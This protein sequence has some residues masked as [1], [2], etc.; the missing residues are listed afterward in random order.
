ML[1]AVREK[2][3]K[4]SVR[5][6][7]RLL[8][9]LL[10]TS[11]LLTNVAW[12]AEDRTAQRALYLQALELQALELQSQ[13]QA[14]SPEYQS[15]LE[16]LDGYPLLPYLEYAS[17]SPRIAALAAPGTDHTHVVEF[18]TRN[19]G[20]YLGQRL[21]RE[22]VLALA[23][24]A[25]W[26]DV[27]AHH[28]KANTTTELTCYA[29]RARLET[30][31]TSALQEVAPLWNVSVSQPNVCDPVFE[32]WIAAGYPTPDIA[33]QRFEKTLKAD[34]DSLANYIARQMPAREQ[35]LARLYMRVD[36]EPQALRD[37]PGF[38][39]PADTPETKAI[40][41]HGLRQLAQSDAA[42]ALTLLKR[43]DFDQT[44]SE[45]ERVELER[46]IIMRLL[47][48]G[49]VNEAEVLLQATPALI[50]EALG[51]WILRDALK[52]Q[53]WTRIETWLDLLPADLQAS[54][55]W[56]YWR[57]RM[58]VE[59]DTPESRAGARELYASLAGL[60]SFYGFM[61]ADFLERD[62][63]MVDKPIEA[64]SAQVEAL[65]GMPAIVRAH[66][67]YLIGEEA[68]ARAEWQH[69]T[70]GMPQE[71][72]IASGKLA[73]SWGWHRNG[74][75]AMIQVSYWDDLQLRFP[76][77]YA[78]I[79]AE[80]ADQND[81]TPHLVFAIA[82]Q[83]SAFMQDVRSSAGAMGLMQLMPATA[84]QTAKGVGMQI[85]NQDLFRPEVNLQ[86]GSRY[87]SQLMEQFDGNRILAAAAYNA[88]PN[89]VKRWLEETGETPV[90]L[91]IWIETIP[92]GETRGYVQNVLAY[93][94]I[95]GYRMG[96]A[97][98]LL[99][100]DEAGGV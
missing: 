88:G 21:E 33:W 7:Q 97:I 2:R 36:S 41:L 95:Y 49:R 72:I 22:W 13:S 29:L 46:F 52:Q 1:T 40:I 59:K 48:Q 91:D 93:S 100:D 50:S 92:F 53:D 19:A 6:E 8:T 77:A 56:Q 67:L 26:G 32:T 25:R 12:A 78:D 63:E 82:R 64:D 44:L 9:A 79:V 68:S 39:V 75:Q 71:Q 76:L 28:N 98:E 74:I 24:Q 83:E 34:Q 18:L 3:P 90:P 27:V 38:Q 69:A 60:R 43:D 57:A 4:H 86:L 15:V 66:E 42:Q 23:E 94:V 65:T 47:T 96:R 55:R 73:D 80:A 37:L 61:A 81:L 87:L 14:L 10:S 51:G 20:T 31:D 62:Y 99:T 30:G 54:E 17:L 35:E 70:A 89:R 84:Q 45:A 5:L 16:Q 85:T 11:L 58:L